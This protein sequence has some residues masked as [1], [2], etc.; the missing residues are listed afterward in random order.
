MTEWNGDERRQEYCPVHH[1]KCAEIKEAGE[2]SK[3]KV[4][5]WIFKIFVTCVVLV[6]GY[7]NVD[8]YRSNQQTLSVL[9]AHVQK[10]NIILHRITH[11][12]NEVALNQRKVM[13]KLELEFVHLP[14]YEFKNER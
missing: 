4:P 10:S 7:M 11:G 6:L 13:S 14:D 12:L 1:I 9:D 8:S 3:T 2:V 5:I